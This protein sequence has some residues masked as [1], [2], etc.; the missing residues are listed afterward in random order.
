MRRSSSETSSSRASNLRVKKL[1]A[2]AAGTSG[3]CPTRVPQPSTDVHRAV[4]IHPS[5]GG[6]AHSFRPSLFGHS[7]ILPDSLE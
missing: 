4:G 5:E 3:T 1:S 7:S 6:R 2:S